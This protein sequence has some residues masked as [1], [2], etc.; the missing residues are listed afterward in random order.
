[1][2]SRQ[3]AYFVDNVESISAFTA[4]DELAFPPIFK[5]EFRSVAV[6]GRNNDAVRVLLESSGQKS[7]RDMDFT[8]LYANIS[9]AKIDSNG[10][11]VS[12]GYP[13]VT[14]A[15]T[16]AAWLRYAIWG[17]G[18]GG[19]GGGNII[20][21]AIQNDTWKTLKLVDGDGTEYDIQLFKAGVR[22]VAFENRDE[23]VIDLP[24]DFP[25]PHVMILK[26]ES[27]GEFT[28]YQYGS[29]VLEPSTNTLTITWIGE[30]SGKLVLK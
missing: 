16:L 29:Y 8:C 17:K 25:P 1:M 22:E 13:D 6:V 11:A 24:D 26:E 14:N 4:D 23:M 20:S 15:T 9:T 12:D 18:S 10:G 5:H 19:A 21:Y 30:I 28:E 3:I 27:G 2:A 7:G